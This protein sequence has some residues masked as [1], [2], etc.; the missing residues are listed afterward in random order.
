MQRRRYQA[1][2][3]EKI[4]C[5]KRAPP[6]YFCVEDHFFCIAPHCTS[7]CTS[8]F[9]MDHKLNKLIEQLNTI[10][11][12]SYDLEERNDEQSAMI[13]E[14]DEIIKQLRA[15]RLPSPDPAYLEQSSPV[16]RPASP[17]YWTTPPTSPAYRPASPDYWTTPP[18]YRPA[19]PDYSP[20][21]N[22]SSNVSSLS[23]SVS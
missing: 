15:A 12:Y 3:G 10:L 18:D 17:V 11:D 21:Y 13:K 8:L 5:V 19:S 4:I 23:P 2:C 16:Y 20:A 6:P 7:L 1:D 9:E 22:V 14:Q